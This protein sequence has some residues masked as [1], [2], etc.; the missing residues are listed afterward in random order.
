MLPN[1]WTP[2][3]FVPVLL[4][5]VLVMFVSLTPAYAIFGGKPLDDEQSRSVPAI[6]EWTPLPCFGLECLRG[7]AI[8]KR[9][10]TSNVISYRG[11]DQRCLLTAR[12]A[13]P[14]DKDGNSLYP[15]V[16]M[17]ANA[18]LLFPH[19]RD[20]LVATSRGLLPVDH[21][22]KMWM[23]RDL[24][25]NWVENRLDD[26]ETGDVRIHLDDYVA[27]PIQPAPIASLKDKPGRPAP[28]YSIWGYGH[29]SD[30][31]G[32][33]DFKAV[34]W[35]H[36][37]SGTGLINDATEEPH[38]G[39]A[40][41][42][43]LPIRSNKNPWNSECVGDSGAA[44]RVEGLGVFSGVSFGNDQACN[45]EKRNKLTDP[46]DNEPVNGD[47]VYHTLLNSKDQPIENPPEETPWNEVGNWEQIV[48][49]VNDVCTKDMIFEVSGIGSILGEIE[50]PLEA[51]G[52]ER[53]NKKVSCAGS[54]DRIVSSFG[55]CAEAVHQPE[56]LLVTA[57]PHVGWK[58][59]RWSDGP[60][61]TDPETD[62]VG[63]CPCIGQGKECEVLFDEIGYY[64]ATGSYDLSYCVAE[65]Q[66]VG[67]P[68]EA[69]GGGVLGRY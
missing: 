55:D 42:R 49:M 34:G 13:P 1:P 44:A 9:V 68:P 3:K 5:I 43:T 63:R 57:V 51:Y 62:E 41:M 16:V 50:A 14:R 61:T 64:S 24:R 31:E 28:K 15:R 17:Q 4:T 66:E 19:A 12:H 10:A 38:G 69:G 27:R 25:V 33:D 52:T 35:G 26:P 65:F 37:R 56:D 48:Y 59:F 60:F 8:L 53:L 21:D 45:P 7:M 23:F 6:G 22:E 40:R 32:I 47:F 30:I 58:F 36:L 46:V 18:G 11:I 54:A 2:P 29:N 67:T 20:Q 39:G